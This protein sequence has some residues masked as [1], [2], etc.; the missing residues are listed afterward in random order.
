MHILTE[1][2][3]CLQSSAIYTDTAALPLR[4]LLNLGLAC[5]GLSVLVGCGASTSTY[6]KSDT[7]LGRIIVYRNGV[8][9]FERSATVE[10]DKLTLAAPADKVDDFLKSLTVVDV[11]TGEAAPI[12]YPTNNGGNLELKVNLSGPGPHQVRLSYVTEAPAWKPSYRITIPKSGKLAMEA[13]AVVDN[14]SGE[15]WENVKL[16]V[17][18]SSAMSFRFDLRGLRTV[19]RQTL[20]ADDLFAMAP[21]TGGATFG[22]SGERRFEFTDDGLSSN[23][24]AL[25][26]REESSR[27]TKDAKVPAV[28]PESR[29]AGRLMPRPPST[30]DRAMD[31][32]ARSAGGSALQGANPRNGMP[33]QPSYAQPQQ[34]AGIGGNG[35]SVNGAAAMLRTTAAA[36]NRSNN[37]VVIEG[38]ANANDAD[39]TNASLERANRLRDQLIREGVAPHRVVAQGM[40]E[41]KG[42]SGGAR[43]VEQPADPAPAAA[44]KT[45]VATDPAADGGGPIGTSHF[46]SKV[47]MT[48]PKASSAMVSIYKGETNGEVVYLYD[49]E[50]ARG[51]VT[52]PF[53]AVRFANPTDSQLE[54]GPVTVFGEGRFI[55]E[56]MSEP[57]P[58]HTNAF[59]PFAL[60]RQIVVEHKDTEKDEIARVITVQRGVFSTEVKHTKHIAYSLHNRGAE[61]AIV[62]IKHTVPV[63]FKLDPKVSVAEKLGNANLL[64]IELAP[65]AKTDFE[66]DEAT[67]LFRSTDLRTPDG[68][69]L[70]KAFVSSGALESNPALRAQ[71]SELIKTQTEMAN[72][73][74]RIQ[75]LRE[76]M[77][78]YRTRMDELHGQI[79]T[80]RL[81]KTAGPIMANLERKLTE[82]SEKVSRATVD[83]VDSQEKLMVARI[84]FQD[85]VAEL[86]LEPLA[87]KPEPATKPPVTAVP[88]AKAVPTKR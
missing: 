35:N 81:V 64:R 38:Y 43:I 76:Q 53:R 20:R 67:P 45:P 30:N 74:Q 57:I 80:L 7:T 2:N 40:G 15:D 5:A 52:Y 54:Q 24:Q 27:G 22:G 49:A 21:P 4:K 70:V 13:W 17:G 56:G 44:T 3:A 83:I 34:Q 1:S 73:E 29:V 19:D 88:A 78:E 72:H 28:A 8:A 31:E 65:N 18:S 86:S 32:L 16:G 36:L 59:V 84:R 47:A 23:E 46:E 58:A 75:T 87:S 79:V 9:Y 12:S 61:K 63:G 11:K 66:F 33:A 50:S 68:L 55:G 48:V 82:I 37:Q 85:G 39:K 60:D 62:Y 69:N 10:G 51:N 26:E 25:A 42:R 77:G 41:Q 14:T 6:V 71:I